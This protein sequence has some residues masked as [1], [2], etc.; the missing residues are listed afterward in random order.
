MIKTCARCGEEFELGRIGTHK[1]LFCPACRRDARRETGRA[2]YLRNRDKILAQR[3]A[4]RASKTSNKICERCGISFVGHGNSK[5]CSD[6]SRKRHLERARAFF[7]RKPKKLGAV[8]R[9]E[10]CGK[11]FAG[12]TCAKYCNDCRDKVYRAKAREYKQ[13]WV[14]AHRA[15]KPVTTR[16][17]MKTD[18][19]KLKLAY[20]RKRLEQVET[21]E[22]RSRYF[23]KYVL[24]KQELLRGAKHD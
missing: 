9:C 8:R 12:K 16:T 10:S 19:K 23:R 18:P 1:V 13:R 15:E 4:N 3:K 5:Y 2:Y 11:E 7:Q 21:P 20:L 24:L 6:C 17:K 14:A 22:A